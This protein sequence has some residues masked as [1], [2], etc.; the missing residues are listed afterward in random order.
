M[1]T[2][3]GKPLNASVGMPGK[4]LMALVVAAIGVLQGC[5]GSAH[6][7]DVVVP[8]V[9][10]PAPGVNLVAIQI[11][12][13]TSLLPL[14]GNRQLI[15]TGIYN[16]GSNVI[17][18]SQVTWSTSPL[19]IPGSTAP[20]GTYVAVN[21]SGMASGMALG[22]SI[23]TASAGSVI[24]VLQLTVNSDGF[25]A[26]TLGILQVP[27]KS[28]TADVV[29]QPHSQIQTQG[30]YTVEEVNLD[31][32]QFSSVLPVPTSILASVPMPA[33]FVP[34]ATAV[35]AASML[36]AVISYSSPQV[37]IIDASNLSSDVANNTV[38]NTFTAP[39]TQTVTFNGTTCTICA[40]VVNPL[41]NQLL[42]STA[43][44]YYSMDLNA[45]TFTALSFASTV[46]PSPSFTINPVATPPYIV[47]PT[48]GNGG[49]SE[50][51]IL[52]LPTSSAPCT[53]S[54]P[55]A[56]TS[57]ANFGVSEPNAASVYLLP[58]PAT[59]TTPA[60]ND[61]AVADEGANDQGLVDLAGTPSST[62][63]SSVSG[64]YGCNN[65]PSPTSFDMASLGVAGAVGTA[66]ANVSPTLF[67]S[68]P[69]GNCVAFEVWPN[70]GSPQNSLTAANVGY[71]YGNMPNTPDG[72][73][74]TNGSD[75]NS[76]ATFTS[77]VS[78]TN[79]GV[80]VDANQNWI[81]KL[82]LT[83]SL[84]IVT[85]STTGG[86]YNPPPSGSAVGPYITAG[87]ASDSVVFLQTPD[88]VVTLSENIV[89][90][91]TIAVGTLSAQSTITLTNVGVNDL[92]ITGLAIQGPNAADFAETDSCNNQVL[93]SLA[94]C[95]IFVT[96]TPSQAA[97]ESAVLTLTD[98]GGNIVNPVCPSTS[99]NQWVC[100]SGTG[101]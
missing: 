88:S 65:A 68:Q 90:F 47:S 67:L 69:A 43:E 9:N 57:Y 87:A 49:P 101:Q 99:G 94:K 34:N 78:H 4:I 8:T 36:V 45:G 13:S 97:A 81:A 12:P 29:Y 18:T 33:G 41:T 82:N 23:V 62:T 80:L 79:Y 83:G 46:Y 56:V 26:N 86:P 39:V 19:V 38:I 10:N 2:S 42:L 16:D 27:Y 17:I 77:V 55:C 73:A 98:N 40:A 5:A 32:D 7:S 66:A 72:N 64:L 1:H 92:S 11:T 96:F 35:S 100:L 85:L 31:A 95:A 53:A 24:G 30:V 37:Q 60:F 58:V 15:A 20:T 52:T 89:N 51:Q 71:A 59:A 44:G 74:F 91:G 28:A 54:S 22:T 6:P 61:L 25:V 75:P 21:S 93:L 84:G 3:A 50:V 48:F 63:S 70:T 76:I 14:A